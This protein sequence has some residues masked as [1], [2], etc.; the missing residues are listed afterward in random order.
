MRGSIAV[1]APS[2]LGFRFLGEG[3][4]EQIWGDLFG[5][6]RERQL[7][8]QSL[9]VGV[10]A[11]HLA[12]NPEAGEYLI[13][14]IMGIDPETGA[15][16]ARSPRGLGGSAKEYQ[17]VD[18]SGLPTLITRSTHRRNRIKS[19]ARDRKTLKP[20]SKSSRPTK[21]QHNSPRTNYEMHP[22]GSM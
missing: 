17:E 18:R 2:G 9:F 21:N 11:E 10:R 5:P 14:N 19:C 1:F 4:T 3:V 15:L 6:T 20:C 12:G 13:R 8:A 7:A 22:V 16:T